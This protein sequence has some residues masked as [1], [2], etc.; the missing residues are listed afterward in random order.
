MQLTCLK[1]VLIEKDAKVYLNCAG[2]YVADLIFRSCDL[3]KDVLM[4]AARDVN[5][6][7]QG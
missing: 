4:H 5:V 2:Q 7:A 6:V 3:K 1:R